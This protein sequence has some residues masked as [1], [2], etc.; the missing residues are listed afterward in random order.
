MY[1]L[2]VSSLKLL[3]KTPYA[4]WIRLTET[5]YAHQR[6]IASK[7]LT[8]GC[9]IRKRSP[10]ISARASDNDQV[11]KSAQFASIGNESGTNAK[12]VPGGGASLPKGT[13]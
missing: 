3:T 13:S 11:P 8:Q 5:L 6:P 1:G 9:T 12:Q 4:A 10:I 7:A 2:N